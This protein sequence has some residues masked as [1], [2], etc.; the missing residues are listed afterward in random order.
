M[1]P[2]KQENKVR[3]VSPPRFLLSFVSLF[4]DAFLRLYL[5]GLVF[6]GST[7]LGLV[8]RS[9]SLS[10]RL[11]VW[12]FLS[13]APLSLSLSVSLS[14][15]LRF[16]ALFLFDF[17]FV[18]LR[19][20]RVS[21]PFLSLFLF[22]SSRAFLLEAVWHR[23]VLDDPVLCALAVEDLARLSFPA[24]PPRGE[25][26]DTKVGSTAQRRP[27]SNYRATEGRERGG[28]G[29]KGKGKKRPVPERDGGPISR[30]HGSVE[31]RR[32]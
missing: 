5:E 10:H 14:S 25:R 17:L 15:S 22:L 30:H 16:L 32:S 23:V 20:F 6:L 28:E 1:P 4:F 11:Q 24:S 27:L 13:G 2:G 19:L 26:K 7:S 3:Y 12:R 9:S 29:R 21:S 31:C 18:A 8:L